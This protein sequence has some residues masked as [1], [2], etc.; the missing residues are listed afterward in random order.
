MEKG[1]VNKK[2]A[3]IIAIV[4]LFFIGGCILLN[5]SLFWSFLCSVSF[6]F[7]LL[8]RRGFSSKDLTGM[9]IEG[10]GECKPF[11]LLILLI[12]ATVSIWLSSGVVPAMIYYGFQYMKKMNFLLAAFLISSLMAIFIGTA[13]GTV[14]TIG[15]ALLGIG[16]GFGI[17]EGM[18]LGA[19]I[20]GAYLADKISPIS[21]LLNLTLSTTQTTYKETLKS[22]AQTLIPVYLLVAVIYS[23]MG[24]GYLV[25]ADN[26][27]IVDYQRAISQGFNISSLLLLLPL[28]VLCL[29]LAGIKIIPTISLG[30][31]GGVAISMGIQ[32]MI[33]SHVIKAMVLGF[34][35]NTASMELNQILHSGGMVAMIEVV[36]IVAGA[37]ALSSL[38]ERCGLISLVVNEVVDTTN[39]K[40]KLIFKTGI[41][42]SI[43]TIATCDQAVGIIIPGRQLQKKYNEVGLDNK[44]LARTISDT[45]TIIAP[46]IPWNV[47]AL[48]IGM[49]TGIATVNYA[50]YAILCYIFPLVTL[51]IGGGVQFKKQKRLQRA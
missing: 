32:K 40:R 1:N 37:I 50:P 35:G 48:I 5:A 18:L 38:L 21:G 44:I 28:G 41:I 3:N 36:L 10:L 17:P 45:G 2:D 16:R 15:I 30:L 39:S 27:T 7:L 14:S 13:V 49:I 25:S 31:V 9:I 43:L 24:K 47:N 34:K 12:G 29:T 4:T 33:F 26:G 19:I 22:M 8:L 42:S 11:F 6:T 23:L 46:L 20:S 51:I